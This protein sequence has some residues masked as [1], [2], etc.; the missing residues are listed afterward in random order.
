MARS[1]KLALCLGFLLW[2]IP[3]IISAIVFPLKSYDVQLFDSAMTLVTVLFV[4]LLALFYFLKTGSGLAEGIMI[5]VIWLAISIIIDLF[6]FSRGPMAMPLDK[7]LMDIGLAYLV[8][9]MVT[10]GMG[11]LADKY[12][13]PA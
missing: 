2:L 5:G 1:L 13:A 11:Y 6:M 7:Y 4:I 3:F 9:P 12:K 8:Y 10:T